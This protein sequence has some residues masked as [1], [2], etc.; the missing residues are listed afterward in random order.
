[1]NPDIQAALESAAIVGVALTVLV[2]AIKE[3]VGDDIIKGARSVLLSLVLGPLLTLGW[4]YLDMMP[5]VPSWKTALGVG[6]FVTLV[7]NGLYA[8]STVTP[9]PAAGRALRRTV[10]GPRD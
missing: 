3:M 5:A 1:M 9:G 2:Q 8:I 10:V 4:W 6:V 7:G